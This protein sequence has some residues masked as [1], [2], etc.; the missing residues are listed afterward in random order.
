MCSIEGW[1][2]V[3]P[4]S[5]D[6]HDFAQL[7][8]QAYE[9]LLVH[10][11]CACHDLQMGKSCL[12]FVICESLKVCSCDDLIGRRTIRPK[13][14]L[15][16]DLFS[17]ARGIPRDDLHADTCL[18]ALLDSRGYFATHGIHDAEDTL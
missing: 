13:T 10:R 9:A 15:S 11:T 14:D 3:G 7:L 12:G 6:C 4:I 18:S 16:G 5:G 8:E 2:I 1:G 17:R